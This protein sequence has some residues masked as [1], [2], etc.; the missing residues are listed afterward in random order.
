MKNIRP[1]DLPFGSPEDLSRSKAATLSHAVQNLPE[2][3][4]FLDKRVSGMDC[5][6]ASCEVTVF[7]WMTRSGLS[8]W[9]WGELPR[10]PK[11]SE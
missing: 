9:Q 5:G 8:E 10:E 11:M 1:L 2:Y 6:D 7:R 3:Q 4:S